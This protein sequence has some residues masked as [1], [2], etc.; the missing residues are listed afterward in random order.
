MSSLTTLTDPGAVAK[1]VTATASG[2]VAAGKPVVV[3]SNGTV[4]QVAI[5][6]TFDGSMGTA[7]DQGTSYRA[8]NIS[9][10]CY[11][12]GEDRT[13]LAFPNSGNNYYATCTTATINGTTMTM[14]APTVINSTACAF[15]KCVYDTSQNR[16]MFFYK[17]NGNGNYAKVRSATL[18]GNT[19]TFKNEVNNAISTQGLGN[20]PG[21]MCNVDDGKIALLWGEGPS[22]ATAQIVSME[23]P[24]FAQVNTALTVSTSNSWNARCAS[25]KKGEF[26]CILGKPNNL[27]YVACTVSGNTITKGTAVTYSGSYSTYGV[28]VASGFWDG[29]TTPESTYLAIQQPPNGSAGDAEAVVVTVSGTTP[30]INTALS[31]TADPSSNLLT[32]GWG[33]ASNQAIV[34]YRSQA[35]SSKGYA[36]ELT[37]SGTT[38]TEGDIVEVGTS[39]YMNWGV[40]WDQDAKKSIFMYQDG[41][42]SDTAEVNVYTPSGDTTSLTAQN[43]L[44]ISTGAASNTEEVST[45]VRGGTAKNLS[46]LTVGTNYYVQRNGTLGTTAADPSVKAG[47]AISTTSLLLTGDS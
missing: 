15:V 46:S 17:Y 18:S 10:A 34:Y 14:N 41:G 20:K 11:H 8:G 16:L 40:A 29:Y 25:G 13:V 39:N 26:L 5:T 44:G 35:T 33:G 23:G 19:F 28:D 24:Q 37:Y 6:S 47:K 9:G 2:A 36:V 30:T 27:E 32:M 31:L 45:I 43:F 12:T 1:S 38:V 21:D 7:D 22:V 3:N 42:N 4:Q